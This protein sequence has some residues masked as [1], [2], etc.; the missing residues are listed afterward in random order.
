MRAFLGT[1]SLECAFEIQLRE[2]EQVADGKAE[3]HG[4]SKCRIT[5]LG[6]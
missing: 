2:P 1:D 5:A 6:V 4:F 3:V